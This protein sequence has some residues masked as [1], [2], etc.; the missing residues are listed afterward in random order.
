[1]AIDTGNHPKL[2]FCKSEQGMDGHTLQCTVRRGIRGNPRRDLI[3][4]KGATPQGVRKCNQRRPS[5]HSG[6]RE[7]VLLGLTP[8]VEHTS[9]P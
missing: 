1:M 6:N 7:E 5:I 2:G 8:C 3:R 4:G 9:M